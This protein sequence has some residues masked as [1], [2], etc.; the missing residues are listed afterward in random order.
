MGMGGLSRNRR[1][2]SAI[3]PAGLGPAVL[4][5]GN[6]D[7]H[8][9]RRNLEAALADA[10]ARGGLRRGPIWTGSRAPGRAGFVEKLKPMVLSC[11]KLT[12]VQAAGGVSILQECAPPY[13]QKT[14]PK[15]ILR[16]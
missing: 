1:N 10:L 13:G 2:P 12:L 9:V 11:G 7:V 4:A 15:N 6:G 14:G 3:W 5:F 8:E 16:T